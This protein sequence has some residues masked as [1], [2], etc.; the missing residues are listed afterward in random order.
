MASIPQISGVYKI[1]CT[2]NGKIYIGS[3]NNLRRRWYEHRHDLKRR[4]HR[5]AHL[6]R[7]WDQY[8][9]S[10]F[11]FEI[12]ELV[13]PWSL[14][15]RENHWLEMLRPFDH[16]IGFNIGKRAESG[17]SGRHHS[18]ETRAK[19]SAINAGR[20]LPPEQVENSALAHKG[21]KRSPET[22]EKISAAA[23]LRN[24]SPGYFEKMSQSH[25]GQ[26]PSL[27]AREATSRLRKGIPLS[28]ETRARM[29]EAQK[30]RYQKPDPE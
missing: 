4:K 17:M 9:E 16:T 22:R 13:M 23:K 21:G 12:V 24:Q 18:P 1:T 3:A 2:A 7:A 6:Q 20:K 8:G 5:N 11:K 28:D 29:S 19:I 25:K 10:S 15:D 14:I 27:A 30:K 26:I